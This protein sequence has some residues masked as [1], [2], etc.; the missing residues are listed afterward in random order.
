M[1]QNS[2]LIEEWK[3]QL[4]NR[5]HFKHL[6]KEIDKLNRSAQLA[7][8]AKEEHDN[9]FSQLD[10]LQCANCC[11][12]I[13]ALVTKTDKKRISKHL[14]LSIK[15][16]SNS[17]TKIDE[18]GDEV[19]KKSPCSFLNTDNSCQIYEV[20]PNACRKYPH[21]NGYELVDNLDLLKVN[22]RYCPAAYSITKRLLE[23]Q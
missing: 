15:Q 21:T 14:G 1:T 3:K 10:C 2:S 22:I 9:V 17:Y 13:P 8:E 7:Q 19:L 20:R 4:D 23:V 16:F 11:K 12:G 5:S 6:K 18:D